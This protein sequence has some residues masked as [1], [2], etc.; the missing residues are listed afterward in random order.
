MQNNQN[1]EQNTVFNFVFLYFKQLHKK[2]SNDKTKRKH[3]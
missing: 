2:H 1:L 3:Q